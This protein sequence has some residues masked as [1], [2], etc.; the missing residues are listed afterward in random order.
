MCSIRLEH[1]SNLI[2]LSECEKQENY[3][4]KDSMIEKN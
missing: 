2:V 4:K 3:F 1:K